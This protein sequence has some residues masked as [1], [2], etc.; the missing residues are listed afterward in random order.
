VRGEL[1]YTYELRLGGLRDEMLRLGGQVAGMVRRAAQALV[2]QEAGPAAAVV[3]I[4]G[5]ADALAVRIEEQLGV[6]MLL[7]RPTPQGL[8]LTGSAARETA[9]LGRI[10]D[11]AAALAG[12]GR[13]PDGGP[14]LPDHVELA[15]MGRVVEWMARESVHAW[16]ESDTD[17]AE[18]V[19][20]RDAEVDDLHDRWFTR[21]LQGREREAPAVRRSAWLAGRLFERIADHAVN[22]AS[23]DRYTKTW[24]FRRAVP[25]HQC[26]ANGPS[27][28]GERAGPYG[29]G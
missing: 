3:R 10:A 11:C 4:K 26:A 19:A 9:E 20:A 23:C 24:E 6:L 18:Q 17:L 1:R 13:A 27:L 15:A 12:I 5:A 21:L 28:P 25:G 29:A 8:R 16:L 14:A 7:R 2:L 22:I